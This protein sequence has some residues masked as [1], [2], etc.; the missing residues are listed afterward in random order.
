MGIPRLYAAASLK[1]RLG[2]E[3]LSLPDQ[4]S[5]ALCRGLI[6]APFSH[7]PTGRCGRYSAAL[8]RGLIEAP[9]GSPSRASARACIPRLYA[10]ASLKPQYPPRPCPRLAPYSAALCRGLIEASARQSAA[11]ADGV[12]IPRLYAAA[13]L[14]RKRR[15]R[16]VRVLHSYS[17]ALC[18]GLIEAGCGVVGAGRTAAYSAALCR[19]LIEANHKGSHPHD[20][21]TRIPRLYAAASLKPDSRSRKCSRVSWYSAALCRGLIEAPADRPPIVQKSHVFRG[22]MPRPH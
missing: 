12:R 10:A 22:S 3:Q 18:R 17:A 19:G 2:A 1:R 9:R 20:L 21:H 8:C 13:S 6:E 5:A 11:V 16:G 4:Y 15:T 7:R 14:K